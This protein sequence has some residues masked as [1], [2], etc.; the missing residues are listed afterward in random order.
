TTSDLADKEKNT[1]EDDFRLAVIF[2][3]WQAVGDTLASLPQEDAAIGYSRL[4]K[5]LAE[6]SS[7]IGELLKAAP[8]SASRSRSSRTSTS[9]NSQAKAKPAPLLSEDFY[10]VINAAPGNIRQEDL[11]HVAVLVRTALGTAG[12]D[13]FIKQMTNG[14]KGLGGTSPEGRLLAAELL[15]TLNWIN[16][17]KP[18]LPM[19]KSEWKDADTMMLVYTM[20][21]FTQ[22]GI[23]ERDERLLQKAAEVSAQVMKNSRFGNYTR[24]QFRQALDRLVQLLPELEEDKAISLIREQLFEQKATL[25]DLI[26]IIGEIGQKNTENAKLSD[27]AASL[28]TQN[29]ILRALTAKEGE[30]PQVVAIPVTNWLT[31]AEGCFRAG[32]AVA[33]EATQA[34]M[35]LMR[36]SGTR[37][38]TSVTTLAP[39]TILRTAPPEKILKR[40]SPG[41]QQRVELTLL[42][43]NILSPKESNIELVRSYT[44]RHPGTEREVCQDVLAAWVEQRSKPSESAQVKSLRARGL[45]VP[46]QMLQSGS[47]IPLTRL[48]QN[49]NINDF[50]KLLADLR[51]ISP[52]PLDPALIVQSF[53]TLHSG[54]EVYKFDD[55]VAIFGPPENMARAELL[56]LVDGMRGRLAQQWRDPET[57]S[58]A[59]TNRT[60]E[61]AGDEVSNGYRTAIKLLDLGINE[62]DGDWKSFITRGQMFFDAAE[63]EFEREVALTEYVSLRDEAF[64]SYSKAAEIYASTVPNIPRGRWTI[65]PYQAW[66]TV[67]LGASDLSQLSSST[68]RTNPGLDAIGDALRALPGEAAEYHQNLFGDMLSTLFPRIDANL[69]QRFLNAGI[70]ILG[71][72]HPAASA[73]QASLDYYG[74]LLDEVRLHVTVDGPTS[75]GHTQPFGM[76][77]SVE[78]TRQL[79]RESGGF[80]RYL[81]SNKKSRY[82]GTQARD[83]LGN[84]RTNILSALE[85]TFD[86]Q[87]ITF[88]SSTVKTINLP[89]EGWVE[90]PMAYVVL[91]A[92]NAAVDRIPS[93]QID[94]D[95]VDQPGQ[96]VLPILSQLVPLDAVPQSVEPRPCEELALSVIMDQ[97]EADK[98]TIVVEVQASGNG[99]IPALEEMFDCPQDGFEMEVSDSGQVVTEFVSDG[100]D[101]TPKGD[102]SWQIT[103]TREQDLQAEVPFHFPKLLASVEPATIEYQYYKDAD[104]VTVDAQEASKGVVLGSPVKSSYRLASIIG[105]IVVL[106][107]IVG[108]FLL[109]RVGRKLQLQDEAGLTPPAEPTPFSTVAFLRRIK[110]QYASGMRDKDLEA[111]DKQIEEIDSS[112]FKDGQTGDIDLPKVVAKWFKLAKP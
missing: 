59:Q 107:A 106:L 29:L 58:N 26:L 28:E 96:I 91:K 34:E 20:E 36:R 103:Y 9:Y 8:S 104:L 44:K 25:S 33:V 3:D 50:K 100:T 101:K 97:R 21:Y 30:L 23:A 102:R 72:D 77:I 52:E 68:A 47:G 95:F 37:N 15:S 56:T 41:L 61:E 32:G 17:A 39:D 42:K 80:G 70:K 73:S 86:I 45:Y 35:L 46:S 43:V 1:P 74:E 108:A 88:H 24:P 10:A 89:R 27:R 67:M 57:Q 51:E 53:M 84:F 64:A 55:I 22:M 31:E 110:K 85:P 83:L 2:G 78:S 76:F 65:E 4:L 38:N 12:K 11:A 112:Y 48:R 90:T 62:N 60:E 54:A 66:F 99:V 40:L 7:N 71:K 92:K 19:E 94:M 18:F 6:R 93:I 109:R 75:V 49:Q 98:G 13:N 79:L 69:R 87:S 14:L 63:Y 111:L 5:S 16:D 82:P 105:A 81:S